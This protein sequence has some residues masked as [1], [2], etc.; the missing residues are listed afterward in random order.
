MTKGFLGNNMP[1][2]VS[3]APYSGVEL[4]YHHI[5][6]SCL[7]G[8][9]ILSDAGQKGFNRI[10]GRLDK[11]LTIL[12]LAHIEPKKIKSIPDMCDTGFLGRKLQ[13]TR[14]QECHN[15]R[16]Y[17]IFQQFSRSSCNDKIIRISDNINLMASCGY[18]TDSLSRPSSVMF[19]R[20]GDI[21][22]PCGVPA[23]VG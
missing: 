14:F 23:L 3:P 7:V 8:F 5:R 2:V 15:S 18:R 12:V 17:L 9:E 22:P 19:A 6:W 20:T 11:K 16:H 1:M 21:M 10:S 13:S 4:S